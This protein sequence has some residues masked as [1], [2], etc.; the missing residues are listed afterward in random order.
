MGAA[1]FSLFRCTSMAGPAPVKDCSGMFWNAPLDMQAVNS[2]SCRPKGDIK[3]VRTDF[4]DYKPD[5]SGF[6]LYR[7]VRRIG[8][9]PTMRER[10]RYVRKCSKQ[11]AR[12]VLSLA[13][14]QT[15]VMRYA[16]G[17]TGRTW[18]LQNSRYVA[19]KSKDQI[20]VTANVSAVRNNPSKHKTLIAT[21][22]QPNTDGI[23]LEKVGVQ[24]MSAVM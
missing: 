16:Q 14:F 18:W 17:A 22:R 12:A 4:S 7:S 11:R 5:R 23:G 3:F 15:V 20:E 13:R 2:S 10:L 6:D 8:T 21:G 24:V 9:F 1:A 19:Q